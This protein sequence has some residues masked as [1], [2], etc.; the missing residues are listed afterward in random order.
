MFLSVLSHDERSQIVGT[1]LDLPSIRNEVTLARKF[2]G[3]LAGISETIATNTSG[4]VADPKDLLA[5][6]R[7]TI[8]KKARIVK[9][10]II[11]Y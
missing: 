7:K 8:D 10:T 5:W 2:G 1:L 11:E 4:G 9:Q 3:D 6:F